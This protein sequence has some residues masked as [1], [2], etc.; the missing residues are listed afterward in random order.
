MNAKCKSKEQLMDELAEMRHNLD[1]LETSETELS[2][3]QK[4]YEMF[5]ASTPD[6]MVFVNSES[7]IVLVNA[8][9]ERLF[10]YSQKELVGKDL[11]ILIPERYRAGHRQLVAE[12]FS[13]PDVCPMRLDLEIYAL[14]KDGTEFPADISLSPLQTDGDLLVKGDIR[15]ITERRCAEE[16]LERNYHIQRVI[17]SILKISL[18]PVSLDE[19][20]Q[21]IL[22]LIVSIPRLALH[23]KGAIYLVE[24]EP[25]V[26]VLKA[27]HGFSDSEYMP[28]ERVLFG[29]CL[30]GKAA[31]GHNFVYAG[32]LDD[33]HE[34]RY[35]GIYSHGHYCAPIVS[36][37]KSIGLINVVGK[38]GHKRD[39]EEEEFLISTASLLAGIIERN[40]TE[41]EK[42]ELQ[43]QLHQ[44]EKL[45]ALGRL[46]AN[47]AH[48]IRHPLTVVGG[49][50]RRLRKNIPDESKNEY[51]DVIVSEV[52]RL[53]SILRD[54]LAF[55]RETKLK[56]RW[57]NINEII[58]SVSIMFEEVCTGQSI[59]IHKSVADVPKIR[60]DKDKIRE[61]IK[62]LVSNAID[63]MPN[64]GSLTIITAKEMVKGIPYVT[65]KISDTGEGIPEDKLTMIFEPFFTTKVTK[66]VTGPGLT[67]SKNIVEKH[68]GFIKV[69]SQVGEGSTFSIY[70][71]YKPKQIKHPG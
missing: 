13:K 32:C 49:F 59:T 64:G 53:E 54:V 68:G 69:V 71:P 48:E 58:D 65:V 56:L 52:N 6:A 50:A 61:A 60:V 20:L 57:H 62:N 2:R 30:C 70:F 45:T 16:L 41:L 8:Q 29:K 9:M 1:Q 46:T 43:E 19:Q 38:E 39:P 15:D 44:S 27:K 24:E 36:G 23:S 11:S 21:R 18:E 40:K 34:I 26:L 33:T 12:Y 67:I 35:E 66:K 14:K 3:V 51:L 22:E 37:E 42:Q 55:S 28:C 63:S 31:S 47:I 17:S 25:D 10:G 7:R 5:H 4:E